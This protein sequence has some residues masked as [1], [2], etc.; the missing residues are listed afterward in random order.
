MGADRTLDAVAALQA[1]TIDWRF[2]A[3]DRVVHRPGIARFATI[4]HV[5][6]GDHAVVIGPIVME[7]RAPPGLQ[8]TSALARDVT[9]ATSYQ[10]QGHPLQRRTSL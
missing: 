7:Q 6:L 8:N 10:G 5:H 2:P 4:T 1:S 9:A 3:T